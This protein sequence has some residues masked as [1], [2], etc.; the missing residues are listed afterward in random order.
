MSTT[1]VEPPTIDTLRKVS[2]HSLKQK[3][4]QTIKKQHDEDPNRT[5]YYIDTEDYETS[6]SLLLQ[7]EIDVY[8]TVLI[9]M[10]C[11]I[12]GTQPG[13]SKGG[14]WRRIHFSIL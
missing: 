13:E 4:L 14:Y 5:R 1:T 8:E 3:I 7:N 2:M 11:S 10:C 9:G 6:K 12:I